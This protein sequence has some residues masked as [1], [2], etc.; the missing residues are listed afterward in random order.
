MRLATNLVFILLIGGYAATASGPPGQPKPPNEDPPAA[1]KDLLDKYLKA[2]DT[3]DIKAM[4]EL[5]D[6]P[7]LDRDRK[8]ITDRAELMKAL[9]RAASQFPKDAGSRV[10]NSNLFRTLRPLLV[11]EADRKFFEKLVTEDGWVIV[12]KSDEAFSVRTIL[13]R[14]QRGKIAVVGGPLKQNH[15]MPANRIPEDVDSSFDK[16]KSFRLYSLEPERRD[17]KDGFH[18]WHILGET[19]VKDATDRK[20]IC[21]SLRLSAED[22]PGRVANCFNPRHGIR[23]IDG[24]KTVDLV[25]CFHCLSVEVFVNHKQVPGFLTTGRPQTELDAVLTAAKVQLAKPANE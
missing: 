6:V 14:Q 18:G 1:V 10:V 20:R 16:A 5:V 3:K 11:D 9:E 24:D 21:D 19:E 22:N 13:I 25:I 12:V 23:L 17:E 15:L 4:A 8:L 2:V 7:F